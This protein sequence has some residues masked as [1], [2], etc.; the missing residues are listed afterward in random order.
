MRVG[1]TLIDTFSM[2]ILSLVEDLQLGQIVCSTLSRSHEK[3]WTMRGVYTPD[4]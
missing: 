1:N 4:F 3:E 2:L